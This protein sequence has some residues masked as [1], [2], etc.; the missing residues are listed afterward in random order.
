MLARLEGVGLAVRWQEDCSRAHRAV[1]D[2]LIDAFA[3]D[4]ADIAARIGRQ[5]LEELMVAHRVWSEWLRV[6][7]VRKL[8]V[9]AEKA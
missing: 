3:D 9:V 7:R 6:G 2:S 8:A 5:A 1:A 4:A